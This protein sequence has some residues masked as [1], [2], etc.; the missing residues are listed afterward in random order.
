MKFIKTMLL[1]NVLLLVSCSPKADSKNHLYAFEAS[2]AARKSWSNPL[3]EQAK[4][5]TTVSD[6]TDSISSDS[7]IQNFQ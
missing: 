6:T 2:E 1:A 5:M 4:T 7:I 3:K